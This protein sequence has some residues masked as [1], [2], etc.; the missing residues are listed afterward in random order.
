MSS[1][2]YPICF[3]SFRNQHFFSGN[4]VPLDFSSAPVCVCVCVCVCG[5]VGKDSACNAGD[6]GSM[7]RSSGEGSA[8]T[9]VFLPG[10]S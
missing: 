8:T 3:I 7:R 10:K 5:S 9:P 1:Y 4:S 6:P 2:T